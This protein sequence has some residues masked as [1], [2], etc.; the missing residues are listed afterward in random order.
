MKALL[1]GV[2]LLA[3]SLGFLAGRGSVGE[4]AP[5]LSLT[6]PQ[7]QTA[8]PR[9]QRVVDDTLRDQ[10]KVPGDEAPAAPQA[11]PG[12]VPEA[13]GGAAPP[14]QS[15]PDQA[16]QAP[17]DPQE[18][19]PLAPGQQPGQGQGQPQPG[20]GPPPPAGQGQCTL[21]YM[22]GQLYQLQPGQSPPGQQPGPGQGNQPG[23]GQPGGDN[24]LIPLT[25]YTGPSPIPGLPTTPFGSPTT[26]D[27][28][29]P[30]TPAPNFDPRLRS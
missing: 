13:P 28:T 27:P 18:L 30:T 19:V 14:S 16:Q 3:G 26:P 17:N 5:A 29:A 21:L 10:Q 11:A 8:G 25:P 1:C 9:V 12:G 2:A 6:V 23:P 22:N 7:K 15:A 20:Q 4:S 24:E